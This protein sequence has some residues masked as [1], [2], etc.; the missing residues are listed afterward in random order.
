MSNTQVNTQPESYF[1]NSGPEFPYM[2]MGRLQQ[3]CGY[4]LGN[5]NGLEKHLWG[6]TVVEHI[7]VMRDAWDHMP[8]KPEWI[9]LEDIENYEREMIAL[10]EKNQ[11]EALN[12]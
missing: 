7:R 9:S 2:M 6:G 8:E 10:L 1:A 4:F 3:D 5:G 11:A 12:A